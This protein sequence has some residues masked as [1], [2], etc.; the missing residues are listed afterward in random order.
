MFIAFKMV[1]LGQTIIKKEKIFE[2]LS[3]NIAL[4]IAI[5]TGGTS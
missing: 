3:I 1:D 5:S 2:R 4:Y